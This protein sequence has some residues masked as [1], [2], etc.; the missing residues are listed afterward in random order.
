MSQ[1]ILQSEGND[2]YLIVFQ[3]INLKFDKPGFEFNKTLT[4][5]TIFFSIW[6]IPDLKVH[7]NKY[8]SCLRGNYIFQDIQQR[9]VFFSRLKLNIIKI[10]SINRL[11]NKRTKL[12]LYLIQRAQF[13][14]G[15]H[16]RVN[17]FNN[18]PN[19]DSVYF[20]TGRICILHN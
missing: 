11:I 6:I 14:C 8:M 9:I 17:F 7:C 4:S 15:S 20:D 12:F 13:N 5:K 3:A 18:K 10:T 2:I 16:E 19:T 1:L